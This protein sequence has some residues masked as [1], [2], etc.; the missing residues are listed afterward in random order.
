[1]FSGIT[2]GC[3]GPNPKGFDADETGIVVGG[4]VNGLTFGFGGNG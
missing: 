2:L 1:M 4:A 3:L